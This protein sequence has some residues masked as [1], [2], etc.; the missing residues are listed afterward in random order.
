MGLHT[1]RHT[2]KN[3]S[4]STQDKRIVLLGLEALPYAS[5]LHYATCSIYCR[6]VIFQKPTAERDPGGPGTRGGPPGGAPGARPPTTR[7]PPSLPG[8]G[9][10]ACACPAAPGG[11]RPLPHWPRGVPHDS[12]VRALGGGEHGPPRPPWRP[13]E[14]RP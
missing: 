2:R 7:P 8:R 14:R 12:P 4:F 3:S 5:H 1:S 13:R 6:T 10:A 11:G 9:H